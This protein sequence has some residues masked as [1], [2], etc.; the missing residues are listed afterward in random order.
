MAKSGFLKI[1]HEFPYDVS[2]TLEEKKQCIKE[3]ME[4]LKKQGYD[5]IVTNISFQQY[6][7]EDDEWTLM[8]LK[9]QL[10]KTLGMRL[11]IYDERGYPSGGA[12]GKTITEHPEAEARAAVVV[13]ELLKPGEKRTVT[14]PRGHERPISAF[15]YLIEG[16]AATEEEL[17]GIPIRPEW[18]EGFTFENTSDKNLLCMCFF[19]KHMYEGG[20]CQHNCH[21]SRRYIDMGSSEAVQAFIDNTYKKYLDC[22][23]E[24]FTE[25]VAECFFTDEP[26]YMG[27]Y[28]NGGLYPPR[29]DH[30]FDDTLPLYPVVNWSRGLEQD[31]YKA[32]GYRIE[33]HMPEIF[34]GNG[35]ESCKVR[36]DFYQLLSKRAENAYLKGLSEYCE[37]RGAGFSGHLLL[38]DSMIYHVSFEGNF[39][40][41]LR[42]MH[43][44]GIDTLESIPENVWQQAF[45]P[46]LVHSISAF[47]RDGHVM[48]EVS[49]HMQGGKVSDAE[50]FASLLVQYCLGADIF[51]S[52]YSDLIEQEQ[53]NGTLLRTVQQVMRS[54][55]ERDD[56][57][58]ILYYP[59]ETIMSTRKPQSDKLE[60]GSPIERKM[61]QCEQS[62]MDSMYAL[63][64]RQIPFLFSDLHTMELAKKRNPK[65]VIV[66]A[67]M[68][69]DE[70]MESLETLHQQG[71]NVVVI[72]D[73][74]VDFAYSERLKQ[75]AVILQGVKELEAWLDESGIRRTQGDTIGVAAMWNENQVLLVNSTQSSKELE[76][77]FTATDVQDCR[78]G[79]KVEYTGS[80]DKTKLTL[81]PYQAVLLKR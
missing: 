36:R 59:I 80:E 14:L 19:E 65:R 71:A 8:Q 63:L 39:F 77:D 68:V 4:A 28:I 38:E 34:C 17:K 26:S 47:Y 3:T 53:E 60:L 33:D 15:G 35:E 52:Y 66:P 37:S 30:E 48:D 11:W 62:M 45:A 64:N 74:E 18:K 81:L 21:A 10:C 40:D 67:C 25:G 79:V 24:Y 23:Q 46:T 31:F 13:R 29:V 73:E 58:T 75:F 5:G 61:R 1:V 57:D 70:L 72:Q 56:G 16:E 51:T 6:L 49:A 43:I 2:A 76:V 69:E 9:A 41:M 32:Y 78:S 55:K 44:P 20:H 50:I 22:L 7:E 12:C 42:H 54:M 27:C